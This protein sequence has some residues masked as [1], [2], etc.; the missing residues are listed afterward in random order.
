MR[1]AGVLWRASRGWLAVRLLHLVALSRALQASALDA[2][3]AREAVHA[4]AALTLLYTHD[5]TRVRITGTGSVVAV[6]AP[7]SS[8][9]PLTDP[10]SRDPTGASEPHTA[11]ARTAAS[12]PAATA[13]DGHTGMRTD[14]HAG[15]HRDGHTA[16]AVLQKQQRAAA[17]TERSGPCWPLPAPAAGVFMASW[18]SPHAAM[19]EA[20]QLLVTSCLAPLVVPRSAYYAALAAEQQLSVAGGQRGYVAV[21]LPDST[22][23]VLADTAKISTF[24]YIHTAALDVA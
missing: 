18:L 12:N 24:T 8:Q 22:V 16:G 13:T 9:H 3:A 1:G 15:M 19:R 14:G 10:A 6:D 7:D 17:N 23:N 21:C 11:S 20:A 5:L 4:A 2:P